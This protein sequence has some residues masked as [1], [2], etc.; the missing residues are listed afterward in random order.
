MNTKKEYFKVLNGSSHPM[1]ER[2]VPNDGQHDVT[3]DPVRH[4]QKRK[5]FGQPDISTQ[6]HFTVGIGNKSLTRKHWRLML[7]VCLYETLERGIDLF[8]YMT[9]EHLMSLLLGQ[10]TDPFDLG[11]EHERR[12]TSLSM[13]I[14]RSVREFEFSPHQ[15]QKVQLCSALKE[16]ITQTELIM[17]KRTY[18]SRKSFWNPEKWITITAVAVET[19]FE[20]SGNSERYSSYCKGYGESHKSLHYKKTRPSAELDGEEPSPREIKLSEYQDLFNL[21]QLDLQ[22]KMFKKIT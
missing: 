3:L 16:Y 13:S 6:F 12:L 1:L 11:N 19:I 7:E 5:S 10:K 15:A 8:Q 14:L 21:N 22:L 9:I 17:D 4:S 18:M 20:R 2:R